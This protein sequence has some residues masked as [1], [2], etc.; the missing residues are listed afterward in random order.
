MRILYIYNS[1]LL[2]KEMSS[3]ARALE[4]LQFQDL[5]QLPLLEA[6]DGGEFID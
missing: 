2:L 3:G 5:R 4:L 1:E 6:D